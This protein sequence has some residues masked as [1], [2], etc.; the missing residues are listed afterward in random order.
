M[1]KIFIVNGSARK[2]G[3][4]AQLCK[5]FEEGVKS[6]SK[7]IEVKAINVFDYTFS[8]CKGCLTCKM[9]AGKNYGKCIISDSIK[10]LLLE[11][12]EADGII[13]GSPI[14]F[15]D[16][17]AQL[18]AFSER[19]LYPSFT[20]KKS[21][22]TIAPKR[23]KMAI[24]YTMNATQEGLIERKYP[25]LLG[26][27]HNFY[28]MVYTEPQIYYSCGTYMVDNFPKYDIEMFEEKDRLAHKEKQFPL[29][30]KA[31]FEMGVNMA[32]ELL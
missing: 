23:L 17:S 12:Q 7:E 11:I 19:L 32:K 6:Q 21:F 2:D 14:Y 20:Y 4:T 27:L 5:A 28:K 29:D 18:K 1:K 26:T 13:L 9:P 31:V 25:E 3:N 10:D 30:C 22:L 15:G 16:M 24:A 8:G